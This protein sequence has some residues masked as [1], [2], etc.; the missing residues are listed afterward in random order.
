MS[1]YHPRDETKKTYANHHTR[2]A[3]S[4]NARSTPRSPHERVP[5]PSV[6]PEPE[7]KREK[8]QEQENLSF[9]QKISS[10]PF[11][12]ACSPSSAPPTEIPFP[13]SQPTPCVGARVKFFV[14]I[15]CAYEC[16]CS[17]RL[18]SDARDIL[19]II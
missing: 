1:E 3:P 7:R 15:E 6:K 8:E 5:N 18:M 14:I 19:T 16:W 2:H 4:P 17:S 10:K 9:A 13:P 11:E 12:R